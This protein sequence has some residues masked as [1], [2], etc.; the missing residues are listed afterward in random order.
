LIE[1]LGFGGL[2]LNA[3]RLLE[4]GDAMARA[5]ERLV[6]GSSV[7]SIWI[8]GAAELASMFGALRHT[9]PGRFLLGVGVSH[10]QIVERTAPGRV[11]S[12][13]LAS[14]SSWLDQLDA[15]PDPI[16][17]EE[18]IVAAL[19]PRMLAIARDR[20]AGSHPYLMPLTHTREAR[21]TLG[22]GKLLA[23]SIL[24]HVGTDRRMARE[25]GREHICNPYLG[26]P[27]Y[28][29][30]WL[31]HGFDDADLDNGGSDRL[32]D[33][34]LASG[35]AAAVAERIREH[36]DAGADHV[37]IQ[38]LS[39]NP[40]EVPVEALRELAAALTPELEAGEE[41]LRSGRVKPG[42]AEPE[43]VTS[44]GPN[45]RGRRGARARGTDLGSL[46]GS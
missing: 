13:P 43:V 7:A 33:T 42:C 31:R 28:S 15:C 14:M 9:H 39:E 40:T 34:I 23:P 41:D 18:R 4:R 32:I 44:A 26:L 21:E 45:V 10:Q 16:P 11:Y 2:W 35:D 1:E 27:N 6:F 22:P 30:N 36:L 29:R 5:T 37:A 17:A 12:R 24:A 25:A 20:S 8:Y 46:S 3:D 38:V 19:S